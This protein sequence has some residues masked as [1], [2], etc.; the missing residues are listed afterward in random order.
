[1]GFAA[2]R[3]DERLNEH[4]AELGLEREETGT[5]KLK[6]ARTIADSIDKHARRCV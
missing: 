1:M 5:A 6:A 4:G 2:G 3:N